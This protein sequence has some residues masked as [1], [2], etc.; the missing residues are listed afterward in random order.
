MSWA[1]T[2]VCGGTYDLCSSYDLVGLRVFVAAP[3]MIFLDLSRGLLAGCTCCSS[4]AVPLV[5]LEDIAEHEGHYS[6][7]NMFGSSANR[8]ER[9]HQYHAAEGIP[10]SDDQAVSDS[11][12]V[13]TLN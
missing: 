6:A 7:T 1:P 2:T 10:Q 4:P 3:D 9:R 12:W 8:N 11:I 5:V 13:W